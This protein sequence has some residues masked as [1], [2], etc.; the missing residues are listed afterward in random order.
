M[1]FVVGLGI[2]CRGIGSSIITPVDESDEDLL[3]AGISS[4]SMYSTKF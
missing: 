3:A 2:T 1:F 4:S